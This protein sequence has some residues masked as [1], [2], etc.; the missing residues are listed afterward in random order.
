MQ[1]TAEYTTSHTLRHVSQSLLT[2]KNKGRSSM[3]DPRLGE[4][5]PF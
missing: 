1:T 4:D 5:L 3:T 2:P